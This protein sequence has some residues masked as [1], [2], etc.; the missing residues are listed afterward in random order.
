MRTFEKTHPWISFQVNLE[1]Q[2]LSARTWVMLGECQS[3]CE[4]LAG[5][6]LKPMSAALLTVMCLT[7]GAQATTAIEGNSLTEE[8]VRENVEG[9]LELPPSQ[10]YLKQEIDN[11]LEAFRQIGDRVLAAGQ[12]LRLSADEIKQY[13]RLVLNKLS[14][15]EAGKPGEISDSAVVVGRYRG[16]PREDCEYLLQRLCDWLNE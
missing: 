14:P 10:Q 7:K 12:D 4:H 3:K 9:K 11:I 13:S 15:N 1:W 6:P 8:Q 16:A 5:T 2:P